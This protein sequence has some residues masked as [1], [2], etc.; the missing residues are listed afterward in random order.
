MGGVEMAL[1]DIMGKKTGLP[2]YQLIGGVPGQ[3]PY[4]RVYEP[5]GL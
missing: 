2:V 1:W 4:F 5:E 3:G